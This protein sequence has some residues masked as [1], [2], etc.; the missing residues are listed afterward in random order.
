MTTDSALKA[1]G[2]P[3]Y[4]EARLD[5][6]VRLVHSVCYLAGSRDLIERARRDNATVRDAIRHRQTGP[7]FGFLADA[8]SYQGVSDR[9]AA[10][11]MERH[12]RATWAEVDRLMS[13]APACPRLKTYW[14][15]AD[16]DYRKNAGTCAEP[17]HIA[18]C[19]LPSH[20][21]RNGRLNQTAYS[22]YLFVRDIADGD[23]VRWIDDQLA[24]AD[25]PRAPDRLDRMQEALLGPLRGVYGVADKVLAMSLS[26]ILLAAP[27]GF[28][29][30][31]EV[32]GSLV[33]VDTLVHNFL[34]RTGILRSMGADHPYGPACYR[35]TG[36]TG[37]IRAIADRIDARAFNPRFPAVFPRFVQHAIWR[38]CSQ[39]GLD[40]CN[41]N[42]ID[43]RA[44]CQNT[45]C[46][47]YFRCA[48]ISLEYRKH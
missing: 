16:C 37:A 3:T 40:I 28:E 45:R 46:G 4:S 38:Y 44:P 33:A 23:L 27:R 13:M 21:L 26:S 24:A 1:R 48:R 32:G 2:Q 47:L 8:L 42:R 20:P 36:C 41:G 34:H 29:R 7:L 14:H 31:R 39:D 18:A 10:D 9:V 5:H 15:F 30:W 22:L 12:G 11:Y 43:D 19:P 25:D 6:A 17:S 35:I